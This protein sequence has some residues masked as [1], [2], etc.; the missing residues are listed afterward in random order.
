MTSIKTQRRIDAV[1]KCAT[2]AKDEKMKVYWY[3]VEWLLRNPEKL[4]A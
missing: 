1:R 2:R 4:R 3:N